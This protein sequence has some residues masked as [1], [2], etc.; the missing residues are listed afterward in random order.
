VTAICVI[1]MHRSGTSAAAQLLNAL[2]LYLGPEGRLF[3]PDANNA[4]GYFEHGGIHAVNEA[5]LKAFGGSWDSPPA[6]PVGWQRL[7]QLAEIK[8]AAKGILEA[9]FRGH[10][11]W[12]WKEPRTNLTLPF[13]RDLVPDCKFV[14]CVRNPIDVAASLETRDHMPFADAY[15]LW[16]E[17]NVAAFLYSAGV[18]RI[19]F[20][21]DCYASDWYGEAKRLGQFLGL[22]V[23]EQGSESYAV[24]SAT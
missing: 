20:S 12:G 21:Y 1:G 16:F 13:W 23:P 14:I 10:D 17:Y 7:P 2:G 8:A 11:L 15:Q 19:V 18:P 5:L 9:D 3:G 24:L 22:D 6:F 4:E